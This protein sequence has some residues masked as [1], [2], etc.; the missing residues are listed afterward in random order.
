MAVL[1]LLDSEDLSALQKRMDGAPGSE[2]PLPLFVVYLSEAVESSQA[3]TRQ[4]V[5]VDASEEDFVKRLHDSSPV[6]AATLELLARAIDRSGTG[7]ISFSAFMDFLVSAGRKAPAATE[8][9]ECATASG[10]VELTDAVTL[11]AE[12][13]HK[14][15][16]VVAMVYMPA[17]QCV[18]VAH[19]H[20][21]VYLGTTG[22]PL[23]TLTSVDI[24]EENITQIAYF[25]VVEEIVVSLSSSTLRSFNI[26]T[27]V[28]TRCVSITGYPACLAWM[29]LSREGLQTRQH[30][31]LQRDDTPTTE[32]GILHCG[33]HEG[34]LLG[35]AL[36]RQ[37]VL[38]VSWAARLGSHPVKAIAAVASAAIVVAACHRHVYVCCALTGALLRRPFNSSGTV[39]ALAYFVSSRTVVFSSVKDPSVL[40]M[41]PLRTL[42]LASTDG[43]AVIAGA[44]LEG[45]EP[46][47]HIIQSQSSSSHVLTVHRNGRVRNWDLSRMCE[48]L[49]HISRHDTRM[50][51]HMSSSC[52]IQGTQ[53]ALCGTKNGITHLQ[54]VAPQLQVEDAADTSIVAEGSCEAAP[55]NVVAVLQCDGELHAAY[56]H[57]C[58][59]IVVCRNAVFVYDALSHALLLRSSVVMRDTSQKL[60]AYNVSS[61]CFGRSTMLLYL[62]LET[63]RILEFSLEPATFGECR[64]V[65]VAGPCE[66]AAVH[67]DARRRILIARLF[68]GRISTHDLKTGT[69]LS[70]SSVATCIAATLSEGSAAETSLYAAVSTEYLK[71]FICTSCGEMLHCVAHHPLQLSEATHAFVAFLPPKEGALQL[72]VV[73]EMA[74]AG[75]LDFT[76]L[77]AAPLSPSQEHFS[78][79][80]ISHSCCRLPTCERLTAVHAFRAFRTPRCVALV[81]FSGGAVTEVHENNEHEMFCV[82]TGREAPSTV[83]SF[84]SLPCGLLV[85]SHDGVQSFDLVQPLSSVLSNDTH[86]TPPPRAKHADTAVT[87]PAQL[88]RCGS[89]ARACRTTVRYGSWKMGSSQI[90]RKLL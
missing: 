6:S 85:G 15:L 7:F 45:D 29:P 66:V 9:E 20:R 5:P 30:L 48:E 17:R 1:S 22:E 67:C 59:A 40:H 33:T 76:L 70:V 38:R 34:A 51:A 74:S 25:E 26:F 54:W 86:A 49:V 35:V 11:S 2:V 53:A 62:G 84:A 32:N 4:S 63:G 73:A 61:A 82:G 39:C 42:S 50:L 58:C 41:V 57:E 81:G 3:H 79:Q 16:A 77:A 18:A 87:E 44:Q 52:C 46:V 23:K 13:L 69:T 10:P 27:G 71:L 64:L 60:S 28:A 14:G 65:C 83:T 89:G 31:L 47:T 68:D 80:L 36:P 24:S 43:V 90:A 8:N 75:V 12:S 72:L 19:P 55:T 21:I 88:T 56:R 37:G 78:L